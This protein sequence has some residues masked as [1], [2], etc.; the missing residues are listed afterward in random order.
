MAF[1]FVLPTIKQVA[2][3]ALDAAGDPLGPRILSQSAIRYLVVDEERKAYLMQVN[4]MH[5]HDSSQNHY[6]LYYFGRFW[7]LRTKDGW[8]NEVGFYK[9]PSSCQS[10]RGDIERCFTDAVCIFGWN[11][12]IL[13]PEENATFKPIFCCDDYEPPDF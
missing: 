3:I 6:M 9:F 5:R 4:S 8:S 10:A 12:N 7:H 2:Q 1:K 13:K 11:G